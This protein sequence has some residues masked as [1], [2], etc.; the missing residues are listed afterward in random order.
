MKTKHI[1]I[2]KLAQDVI[3]AILLIIFLIMLCTSC[4][5][6]LPF[7]K[8][9]V[10]DIYY[11][12]TSR[13]VEGLSIPDSIK[14]DPLILTDKPGTFAFQKQYLLQFVPNKDSIVC[15]SDI[16]WVRLD[17]WGNIKIMKRKH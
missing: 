2:L 11:S 3:V 12:D 16:L 9:V 4:A 8:V 13:I 17:Y 1:K 14:A 10:T 15:L 5:P 6:K 7:R